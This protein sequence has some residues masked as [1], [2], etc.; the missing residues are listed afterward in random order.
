MKVN[1]HRQIQD[2]N[3]GLA[4]YVCVPHEAW[5][6]VEFKDGK[7][8]SLGRGFSREL[9]WEIADS[10]AKATSSLASVQGSGES[11]FSDYFRRD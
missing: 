1:N 3:P 2:E 11:R 10:M 8:R 7:S 4:R 6:V 9:A 5:H